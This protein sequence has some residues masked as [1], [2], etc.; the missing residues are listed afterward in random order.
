[1]TSTDHLLALI[2]STPDVADLLHS[3]FEI[4]IFRDEHGEVVRAAS[5]PGW[6]PS[7]L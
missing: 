5:A 1:M 2:R 7:L 6:S 4:G 3:S